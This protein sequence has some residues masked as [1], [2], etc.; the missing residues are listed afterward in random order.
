MKTLQKGFTLIELMIVVAIIGIL[1]A[2]AVPAYQDYTIKSKVSESASLMAATKTALE[3]AY[4]E[5]N[6]VADIGG[7]PRSTLGLELGTAYKGKYVSYITYGTNAN[8]PYIE[9]GLRASTVA[10][11]LGLGTAD[12]KVVRWV[13]TG[14]GGNIKWEVSGFG[15]ALPASTV[16]QKYLPKN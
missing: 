4:S 7:L 5:G 12:G 14:Q 13:G 2:I 8:K 15:T 10:E 6:L 16:P 11:P 3:V 9:A 1:A